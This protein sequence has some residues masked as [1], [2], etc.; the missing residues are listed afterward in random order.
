MLWYKC[1]GHNLE[2]RLER[3]VKDKVLHNLDFTYFRECV[4]G[5]K[6]KQ[7][8]TKKKSAAKSSGLLELIY[9]YVENC[10]QLVPSKEC[11]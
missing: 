9:I 4:V 6:E 3:L 2:D 5:I 1:L 8:K 7:L 10:T 11:M